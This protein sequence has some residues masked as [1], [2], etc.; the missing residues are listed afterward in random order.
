VKYYLG[1]TGTAHK[2]TTV[3]AKLISRMRAPHSARH[4]NPALLA[5][6]SRRRRHQRKHAKRSQAPRAGVATFDG[7]PV[8]AW[9]KPYLTWAR[10]HGWHGTLSS[11]WRSPE[12]SEHVCRQKCGA[13][14]CAGTCAGRSSNHVGRVRGQ[15]AVDV[16]HADEFARLMRTCPYSPRIFNDLPADRMH[17]SATGH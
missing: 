17:F 4:S 13:P 7:R 16:T 11:G 3:D 8:A 14:K 5:R 12:H 6:A 9:M 1:Y 10:K 2:S 15:G